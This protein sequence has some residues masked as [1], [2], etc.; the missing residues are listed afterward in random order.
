[1]VI[2]DSVTSIESWA[3]AKNEFTSV[4]I[5]DSVTSIGEDAFKDNKTLI[6]IPDSVTNRPRSKL[7]G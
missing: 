2:S 4:V 5:P 7:G 3:F 6:V 1:M